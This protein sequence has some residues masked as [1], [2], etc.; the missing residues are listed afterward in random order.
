M[1]ESS[2]EIEKML[3]QENRE[4][5]RTGSGIY[6]RKSTRRGGAGAVR[7][8]KNNFKPYE[9]NSKVESGNLYDDIITYAEFIGFDGEM[10]Y[11]ILEEW[12]K[13]YS[14]TKIH[15]GLGISWDKLDELLN[16]FDLNRHKYK[17]NMESEESREMM[18]AND[19]ELIKLIKDKDKINVPRFKL[20]PDYQKF[21]IVDTW[22]SK[23]DML[24]REIAKILGYK[25]ERSLSTKKSEWKNEYEERKE[26]GMEGGK[27]FT[28]DF[29]FQIEESD[30]E[31]VPENNPTQSKDLDSVAEN[32]SDGYKNITSADGSGNHIGFNSG[33]FSFE[34]T[35]VFTGDNLKE[36]NEAISLLM[37]DGKKYSVKIL[38]EEVDQ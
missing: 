21:I 32:V 27:Q 18:R 4:K 6:S 12:M 31:I 34:L 33:Y 29:L 11:K 22:N 36:K 13:K 7:F 3:N 16:K 19:A 8:A 9:K 2:W 26:K 1:Q 10:Q 25:S 38:I 30:D 28:D 20:L 5:K 23:Y 17:L 24:N 14:K 15:K 35:G 37:E